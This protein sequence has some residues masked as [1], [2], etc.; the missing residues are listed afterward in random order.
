MKQ[1][2]LAVASG[3]GHWKQL[4]IIKSAFPKNVHFITTIDGLPQ[5]DNINNFT[6]VSDCNKSKPLTIVRTFL[7][8][9]KCVNKLKPKVIISTGAAPGSIALLIGK[10]F[11]C[12]TIWIDSIANGEEL[13]LGGKLSKKFA[14]K[15]LTQWEHLEDD[16][17]EYIGGIY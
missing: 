11:G 3:G 7:S 6:I 10:I 2:I 12:N 8:I 14:D 16:K 9:L 17:A 5:E 4:M 15:V 1:P 13:S